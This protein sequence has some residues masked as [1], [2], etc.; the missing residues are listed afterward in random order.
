MDVV[1]QTKADAR[2]AA[3]AWFGSAPLHSLVIEPLGNGHIHQTFLLHN[4]A[5][6]GTR[7]V[8][9][10]VNGEVYRDVELLMQQTSR[11]LDQL[12]TDI[13]FTNAY[14][15]PDL[16]ITP[17]GQAYSY[18]KRPNDEN[19]WRLWRFVDRSVTCDPP[20]ERAQIREAAAAF[21]AFQRTISVFTPGDLA[22]TIPGFLSMSSYLDAFDQAVDQRGQSTLQPLRQ[23]LDLVA[24]SRQWPD[25]ILR[26]NA[27]IHGDCKI[28]N[29]LFDCDRKRVLAVIDLD[30]CMHGNWAWDFGDL[31]RSI[32]YSRGG[33]HEE[34]Y[35][36]C[37]E[38]FLAGRGALPDDHS[39][40]NQ[41]L[42]LAPGFLAF[43]LG[44][45]FLTDYISGN[46]YFAV[47][48]TGE[49]LR[50]A[51]EQFDLYR[52]F[53]TYELQMHEIASKVSANL[54]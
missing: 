11:L 38:G 49:N 9:Q 4:P 53:Q 35:R 52:Q 26:R 2:R 27:M 51:I 40:T 39:T 5:K 15:V 42:A 21:G 45:R 29:L 41:L 50:R 12:A 32:S 54:D 23:W 14:Q 46:R 43:M 24:A 36:T 34:D 17:H 31:V 8:L 44:L 28:N 30:N 48:Q 1:G 20:T 33:F 18:E 22:Q 37:I 25:E 3:A 10:R 6:E 47:S 7:Y 13:Q 16:V 19:A